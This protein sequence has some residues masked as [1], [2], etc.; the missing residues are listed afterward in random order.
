MAHN[1][2]HHVIPVST[3]VRVFIALLVL[4]ALTVGVS[5]HVTGVNLGAGSAAIAML[6][7][8]TKAILVMGIFM[9][10]KYEGKLNQVIFG[11]A[12]FFL[13]VFYFFSAVDVFTRVLQK[14]PPH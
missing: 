7:A 10:L 14:G 3:Y 2:D 8:S 1:H 6:I 13:L 11:S 12:F 4:T 9:H 5:Y